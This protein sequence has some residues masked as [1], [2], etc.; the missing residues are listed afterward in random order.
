MASV[1][2]RVLV[3]LLLNEPHGLAASHGYA[4][5][6]CELVAAARLVL[7]AASALRSGDDQVAMPISIAIPADRP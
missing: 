6:K 4:H 2:P 1:G 5:E 3:P 7:D